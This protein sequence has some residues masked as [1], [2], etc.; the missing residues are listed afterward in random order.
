[1]KRFEK[2]GSQQSTVM[3]NKPLLILSLVASLVMGIIVT[4]PAQDSSIVAPAFTL[5]DVNG[6][7]VS[8]S[9]FKGKVI[10]IDFWATW[11]GPC[12]L[13]IPHSKRLN[14]AF[15]GNPDIVFIT[16]SFDQDVEKWKKKVRSKKMLGTQLISPEGQASLVMRDYDVKFIPRFVVIGKDGNIIDWQA[17][18]PSEPDIK[19][20]LTK[21]L[22]K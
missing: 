21:I 7:Q 3:K 13:E 15:N 10:Y 19:E 18:K 5:S 11:C 14:E 12:L 9:D 22:E 6:K 20:Y 2:K 16:I 17:K 4:S 8:L 1:M